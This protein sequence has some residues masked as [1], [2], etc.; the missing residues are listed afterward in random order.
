MVSQIRTRVRRDT[1]RIQHP[2]KLVKRSGV[3]QIC[4]HGGRALWNMLLDIRDVIG[5][6]P[7]RVILEVPFSATPEGW[8]C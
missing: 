8:L 6:Q 2:A 3:F 7:G 5:S 4:E 1:W